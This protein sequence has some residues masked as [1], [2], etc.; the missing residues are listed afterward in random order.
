[1][2]VNDSECNS[3]DLYVAPGEGY[4]VKGFAVFNSTMLTGMITLVSSSCEWPTL[5][6]AV[7]KYFLI[8]DQATYNVCNV[9]YY[10][11]LCTDPS[12]IHTGLGL[13]TSCDHREPVLRS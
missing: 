12:S 8:I 5:T 10:S 11:Y 4:T 9:W 13:R 6:D 1:M 2:Q 7:L 3:L